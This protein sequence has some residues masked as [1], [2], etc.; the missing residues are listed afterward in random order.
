[1][2]QRLLIIVFAANTFDREAAHRAKV[3][4]FATTASKPMNARVAK[5]LAA[6][7]AT[8]NRHSGPVTPTENGSIGQHNRGRL[9][10][11]ITSKGLLSLSAR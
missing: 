7:L 4:R 5:K 2:D 3:E 10:R 9:N 1:M 6:M 8:V 11:N